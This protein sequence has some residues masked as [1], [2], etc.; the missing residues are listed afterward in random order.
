MNGDHAAHASARQSSCRQPVIGDDIRRA[1]R[2]PSRAQRQR[3][4]R[5]SARATPTFRALTLSTSAPNAAAMA[6]VLSL[7]DDRSR[8][9]PQQFVMIRAFCRADASPD[10]C[11]FVSAGM[12]MPSMSFSI[13]IF[14]V[15]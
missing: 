1:P 9:P 3:V 5:P 8:A 11:R 15:G 7:I 4:A 14:G 2:Q 12:M 13:R 10:M 6:A